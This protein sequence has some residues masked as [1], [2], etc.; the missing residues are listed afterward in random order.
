MLN[1]SSKTPGAL[2]ARTLMLDRTSSLVDNTDAS[3]P[4]I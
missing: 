2:S 3:G 4:V 1:Q